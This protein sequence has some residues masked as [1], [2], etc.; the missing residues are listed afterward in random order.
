MIRTL[1]FIHAEINS[2]HMATDYFSHHGYAVF[3]AENAEDAIRIAEGPPVNIVIL[4]EDFVAESGF[5][6]LANLARS[7]PDI[8]IVRY[9]NIRQYC[10][11][12]PSAPDK[13][14]SMNACQGLAFD[15]L[16][17]VIRQAA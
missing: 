9:E 11:V 4:D 16:L 5:D 17:Q 15:K 12:S 13:N 2:R 6:L 1:L 3:T 7:L 14:L 8:P 10:K